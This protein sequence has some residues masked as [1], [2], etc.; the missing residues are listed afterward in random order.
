MKIDKTY[1][2]A[3]IG[4]GPGGLAAAIR[5]SELGAERIALI[6]REPF[7]GGILPQCI[8]SGF[9]IKIFKKGLTGPEYNQIFLDRVSESK[10]DVFMDTMALEIKD[11]KSHKKIAVSSSQK[12]F[13]HIKSKTIILALGCRERTR[14]ALA[15]AGTRPSGIYTAGV[16][17]K[18]INLYGLLPGKE[19]ILLGSGDIGLIM[20]RRMA[21]EGCDVKGV[22]EIMPFSS[23]LSR[24]IAQCLYDYSIPLFTGYTVTNIYGNKKIEAVD[25]SKV[26]QDYRPILSSTKTIQCDTLLLSVGLIPENE[27]SQTC[28]IFLDKLTGGPMV[29]ETLQTSVNGIFSCGNS[30]FVNDIADDVTLAGYLAAKSAVAHLRK[31]KKDPKRINVI[32]GKNIA[33]AVPQKINMRE[34]A[35][36]RIRVKYPLRDAVLQI[37]GT[38]FKKRFK[39]VLPGEILSVSIQKDVFSE[40][41]HKQEIVIDIA[42]NH[43]HC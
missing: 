25:V 19:V 23:G 27:L 40:I 17:Q 29:D 18:M 13:F 15:I 30:L 21:L 35:D 9:G 14:G 43:G 37:R 31:I 24:N 16:V 39:I 2:I 36:L 10:I 12:G 42:E 20:A 6:E 33:Y 26:D 8:H 41:C 28:G 5:S 1:D 4:G 11:G 22:Y 34:D 38:S 3:V 7:L 32:A